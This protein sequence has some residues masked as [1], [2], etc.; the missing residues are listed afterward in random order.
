MTRNLYEQIID[1]AI[2]FDD[3]EPFIEKADYKTYLMANMDISFMLFFKAPE[4]FFPNI[5][6]YHF[7]DL[8]KVFD[9]FDIELP[10]PPKKSNYRARC[11]YYWELCEILYSFRKRK[12]T[13]SV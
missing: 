6:R 9:I 10:L 8:I 2:L 12:W 4:Y 3:G 1:G 13:I 5:F 7:F 11:M